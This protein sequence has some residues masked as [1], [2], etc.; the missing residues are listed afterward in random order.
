MSVAD[1]RRE[2]LIGK[3]A[4][5]VKHSEATMWLDL[6]SDGVED[7][8]K[9]HIVI[10]EFGHALGLAHEHQRSDFWKHIKPYVDI[11]KMKKDLNM[12]D[13]GF[14]ASWDSDLLLKTREFFAYDPHSIMHNW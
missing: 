2:S 12:T 1:G 3:R 6:H 11:T 9:K 10:H 14:K 4:Q 8:Y 7:D 5:N 13:K